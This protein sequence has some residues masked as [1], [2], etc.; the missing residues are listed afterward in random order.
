MRAL[1]TTGAVLPSTPRLP[2]LRTSLPA[3]RRVSSW[4]RLFHRR[5]KPTLFQRCLAVHMASAGTLSAL[6]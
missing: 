4:D 1:T 2:A 3:V 5:R 6:R